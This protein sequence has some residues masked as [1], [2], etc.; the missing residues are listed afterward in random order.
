MKQLLA[1]WMN[2]WE[3][4][5]ISSFSNACFDCSSEIVW[6]SWRALS[7]PSLAPTI[8]IASFWSLALGMVIFVAVF[9]SNSWRFIPPFPRRNLWWSLELLISILAPQLASILAN[10]LLASPLPNPSMLRPF[11][12]SA[13]MWN[14]WV[15]V[16]D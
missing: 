15:M 8:T 9:F 1:P 7:I 14:T 5:G 4:F 16:D 12:S 13:G 3:I 6:I 10:F 2:G 11:L